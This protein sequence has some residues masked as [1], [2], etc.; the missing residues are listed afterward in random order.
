MYLKKTIIKAG[1][2]NR[3]RTPEFISDAELDDFIDSEFKLDELMDDYLD[4]EDE[5]DDEDDEDCCP[6]DDLF[7]D[8]NDL[9][10][11]SSMLLDYLDVE[12]LFTPGVDS[13]L[14]LIKRPIVA[15]VK[16]KKAKKV[17]K[18][19]IKKRK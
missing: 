15:P 19:V 1:F 8:V 6:I 9:K 18:K 14:E 2:E 3:F 12:L 10:N 11:L 13:K 4:W 7:E 5:E 17:E 16:V